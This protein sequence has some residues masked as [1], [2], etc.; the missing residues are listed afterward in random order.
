MDIGDIA[1]LVAASLVVGIVY[2]RLRAKSIRTRAPV[3]PV[4]PEADARVEQF[5]RRPLRVLP[6]KETEIDEEIAR[7]ILRKLESKDSRGE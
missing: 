6:V 2:E 4:D 7:A 5:V 3:L 1:V